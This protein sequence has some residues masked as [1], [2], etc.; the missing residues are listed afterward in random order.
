MIDKDDLCHKIPDERTLDLR[1]TRTA[2]ATRVKPS[3]L[4]AIPWQRRI[5][6]P[7]AFP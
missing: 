2:V 1:R 4:T 6:A 5:W 7:P 3:H